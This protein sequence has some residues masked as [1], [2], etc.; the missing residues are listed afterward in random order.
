LAKLTQYGLT[1]S[2]LKT[3]LKTAKQPYKG[4]TKLG[5]ALSKHA[6]RTG[7]EIIWGQTKG[8]S[9]TWHNQ[10][11]KHLRDIIRDTGQFQ[12]VTDPN[13]GLSWIEKRLPDGRG[14]RLNLDQ[15]FKGFID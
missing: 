8:A 14:L 2:E 5:H 6:G 4:S 9:T 12:Q 7:G 3:T 11:M 10:A 1:I 13:T 15:T